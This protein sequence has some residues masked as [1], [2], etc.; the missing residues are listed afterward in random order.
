MP[1]STWLT[2]RL[3][4]TLTFSNL[5]GFVFA[6]RAISSFEQNKMASAT[7]TDAGKS[8]EPT[9]NGETV[10]QPSSISSNGKKPT[11]EVDFLKVTDAEWKKRLTPSQY[12]VT[13]KHG[14]ERAFSGKY[15]HYKK[16]GA[17]RCVCCKA[18]VFDSAQKFDSGTGWPSFWQPRDTEL[19]AESKDNLLGYPRTE[20]HCAR[21]NAHLG[22]VFD[23]APQTPTGL[24]YCI[25]SVGLVFVA[26]NELEVEL[27][28]KR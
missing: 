5:C 10:S 8:G 13:R 2:R 24:R 1:R 4:S 3:F 15:H 25:N 27:K 18:V 23:D 20:I 12:Q 28:K 17:Y 11:E 22:H 7:E 6:I 19:V 16:D 21:C 9:A 26:R 14:T